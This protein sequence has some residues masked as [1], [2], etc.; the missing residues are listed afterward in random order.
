METQAAIPWYQSTVIRRLALSILI[1][2]LALTHLSKFFAGVDLA[3]LV[4]DI[5]QLAAMAYAGWAIHA[6]VT[7]NNPEVV[8]SQAKADV[9]NSQTPQGKST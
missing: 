5:L 2:I 1:Q 3:Q 6:R 9:A 7:K 8:S 4:D